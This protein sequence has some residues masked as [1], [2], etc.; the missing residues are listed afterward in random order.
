VFAVAIRGQR[1]P[2]NAVIAVVTG[3]K[4][5]GQA[6]LLA[7]LGVVNHGRVG[8]DTGYLGGRSLEPFVN[9]SGFSDLKINNLFHRQI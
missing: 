3:Y 1:G 9:F 2:A 6:V 4:I 8:V 5:A 7:V